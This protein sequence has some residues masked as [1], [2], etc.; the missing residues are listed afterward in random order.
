VTGSD[1]LAPVFPAPDE[2]AWHALVK[3]ALK[4]GN[5]D[6]LASRTADGIA[7]SPLYAKA[8]R[9]MAP[10]P[11]PARQRIIQRVDHPEPDAAAAQVAE[12][13][14]G[15]ADGLVL[16]F[17]G[18][19]S[20][21]GFG[22]P[23]TPE[24]LLTTLGDRPLAGVPLRLD[25]A[26][27]TA[28]TTAF[29]DFA[30]RAGHDLTTLEIDLGLP[31]DAPDAALALVRDQGFAGH[32]FLAN[33]RPF[34]EAGASEA[35]E[36]GAVLA[37]GVAALRRLKAS[38]ETL[39]TA[40][41]QISFLL[42]ADADQFL[43]I[44]KFRALRALWARV[45]EACGLDAGPIRLHA[46]TA[47][48]MMTR[49]DPATNILRAAIAAFSATVAGAD[50]LVVLPHTLPFGLPDA[51]ARRIARNMQVIL[52]DEAGLRR[53]AD[54]AA[55]SGAFEALTAELG[56]AGWAAFQAI[57]REGG[58][59]ESLRRGLL[60]GRIAK[61]RERR[62]ADLRAG[63][64]TIIGTTAYRPTGETAPTVL[65]PAPLRRS[66]DRLAAPFEEAAE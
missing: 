28:A 37:A 65:M 3:A 58:L 66:D 64:A 39:E 46:E 17:A 10:V 22:L 54:P 24:A 45:E 6:D 5:I 41:S 13:L 56:Q 2:A 21:R 57:E 23:P 26:D 25:P 36:L 18:S 4:G 43:T 34:H 51:A 20:A 48:R 62:L 42:V 33:G 15:G 11:G 53:V 12:D 30:H 9:A 49:L 27:A 63:R 47:W 60:S 29:L 59:A 50:S 40:R 7:I 31:H 16:A 1:P 38:G 55:G 8:E 14:D 19:A 44:A 61:I 35:Q 32:I 52:D